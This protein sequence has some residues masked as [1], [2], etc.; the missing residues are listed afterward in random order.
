MAS[1][2]VLFLALGE[3]IYGQ[4]A[5]NACMSIKAVCPQLKTC[6]LYSDSAVKSL[7]EKHWRYFD[8]KQECP[9]EFYMY[10]GKK[11]YFRAKTRLYEMSPFDQT[12]WL[13]A[14]VIIHPRKQAQIMELFDSTHDY[15][16]QTYNLWDCDT[17]RPPQEGN[18]WSGLGLWTSLTKGLVNRYELQGKTLPQINSSFVYFEKTERMKAFFD[19]TQRL[20][21]EPNPAVRNW[22]GEYPDEFFFHIAGARLGIQSAKV[23][24]VPLYG[25]HECRLAYKGWIGEQAVMDQHIGTMLYG[26]NPPN[27]VVGIYHMLVKRYH[28]YLP[29]L[30]S[31]KP[32]NHVSK[33]KVGIVD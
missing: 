17:G 26:L 12:L 7:T 25:D 8:I 11:S 1:R 30:R 22:R 28:E 31:I 33:T 2:G 14:D 13:D 16:A 9:T 6:I 29:G 15:Y 19:E 3:Q 20:W 27:Q 23:P 10:D 21:A 5:F 18:I 24:F 32:F 4:M